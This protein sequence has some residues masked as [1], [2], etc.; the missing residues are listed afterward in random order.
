MSTQIPESR[1]SDSAK[2]LLLAGLFVAALVCAGCSKKVAVPSVVQ[3]DVD[4]AKQT[5][6]AQKLKPG[7]ITGVQGNVP[8]G[9]YVVSQTPAA[10]TQV[11]EDS[12]VDLQIEAP[13]SLSDLT[14]NKVTDAVDTLQE[15]GLKV[16][17]VKQPTANLLRAFSGSKVVAQSPSPNT[18]VRRGQVVTLTVATPPDLAALAGVITSEPAYSKLNPEY[19]Q[20]LDQFLK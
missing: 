13:I 12:P 3:Q 11:S 7:N 18:L 10:G 17:F 5:L 16:M 1:K 8:A 14:K 4:Q 15:L 6:A 20:Y 19:R 9:S 2:R